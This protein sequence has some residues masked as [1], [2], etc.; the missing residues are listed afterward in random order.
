M[1]RKSS[2]FKELD[3]HLRKNLINPDSCISPYVKKIYTIKIN[4]KY[5]TASLVVLVVMNPPANAEDVKNMG[6]IPGSEGSLEEGT[7]T[8]SRILAQRIPW[9][10]EPGGLQSIEVQKSQTELSD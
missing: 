10:E 8:H 1:L 3:A 2:P 5:L 9:T 6:L 4:K 7:A